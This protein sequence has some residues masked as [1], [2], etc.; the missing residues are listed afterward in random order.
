MSSPAST[1]S[2]FG[3]DGDD[4]KHLAFFFTL[5]N[6][7]R[8]S[9]TVHRF[10]MTVRRS[11]RNKNISLTSDNSSAGPVW[12][13][14]WNHSIIIRVGN[15]S[16]AS[17][18]IA[19]YSIFDLL[20]LVLRNNNVGM[21]VIYPVDS[22]SSIH[23]LMLHVRWFLVTL[24]NQNHDSN[25]HRWSLHLYGG[26]NMP[27]PS[28]FLSF[29]ESHS[30]IWSSRLILLF[31]QS[32]DWPERSSRVSK[33]MEVCSFFHLVPFLVCL[34][35]GSQHWNQHILALEKRILRLSSVFSCI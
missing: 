29:L 27:T 28:N 17:S 19:K 25:E 23:L 32:S 13:W 5:D 11:C 12:Q 34:S 31:C 20:F 26:S 24:M 30:S 2:V 33:W 6:M 21:C 18:L 22:T 8:L 7:L 3:F 4:E 9:F 1:W 14:R 35:I 15:L 10:T 16:C